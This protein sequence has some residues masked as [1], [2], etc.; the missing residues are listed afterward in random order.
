MV[1]GGGQ[2][3]KIALISDGWRRMITYAWVDG[4]IRRIREL[5]EDIALYQYNCYGNWSKDAL[6]NTGEYNI[7]NLPDLSAFDGIILDGSN[8]VDVRQKEKIVERLQNC[9]VPVLSLDWYI[10][11]FYY[12]GADNRRPIRELMIHLYEVHGCRRFVFAGGPEDAFGNFERVAAYC[13][14]L[15]KYGMTL[16]DNP[17]LC[18]DYD[19]ETGVNYMR[20][21][22]HSG[23]KLPDVFVCAND[24]IA[25]GI[26]A[27][28]EQWGY[29]VPDDFLVTGFDNL[30]KA[31]YFRPQITT[32]FQDR[33]EIGKLC[34]DVLLRIWEGKP[35]EERNYI[36]VTC[37]Y[38]ESCGCPNNG[39]VNYREYIKEKIVATVKK[40]EDDSLLVEL[41]AQMARCNGFREIFEYIVD[42]FQKLRCDGVY[43]VVDRKLFAADEDTD[44]PVEGYDEK[45]LVVADGFE[46][47]KRMA[48]ASVG[49]LNRHLEE[50][51][52]QN[53]YLFTPIHFREQSIG[54]LVMKN[55]RFLYDNPYYY[56]IHSTI[57]KTLETQFKQKQLENAANK[58]QMLYNRDPLTGICNRI[59]YTDIIRPAFA[60]YQEKG[61]ACALVFVDADDFK[62]VNDTYGHEFGDQVLIR[63]AQV[64]EEECPEQ[65]YVCRYGGDEFIGFFPYATSKKAQQYTDRVQSRLTKENIMISIG[66]EL[67]FAGGEETIDEYLSLADQNMYCQKQ[68]RKESRKNI[69]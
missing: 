49:E 30:D 7:Y 57:V 59:A 62:S 34:V 42:Y 8:I 55:G 20:E 11:G 18:G 9:G 28:A 17:I 68:M 33:E 32:V 40:D 61:I 48:F 35:V 60:K 64:L 47:H 50:T 29:R 67:T 65:G 39:M 24:N 45:N 19:Y 21:Y 31:A 3:K 10:S 36:P 14:C 1:Y 51:G 56:D 15:K 12:V 52:S 16:D 38:G 6:H 22:V 53:A 26:C 58:L 69:D 2:L 5:D 66:V 13:E 46:N 25:A 23:S 41:E 27:E 37:I 43:F 44:F 54:Y 4:I 63:I